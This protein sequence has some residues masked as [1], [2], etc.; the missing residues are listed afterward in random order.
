MVFEQR[1]SIDIWDGEVGS[2]DNNR[3]KGHRYHRTKRYCA[4]SR[5]E[6]KVVGTTAIAAIPV[7]RAL[8]HAGA[9]ALW[10]GER[11]RVRQRRTL[12]SE[13]QKQYPDDEPPIH[14]N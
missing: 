6:P 11:H 8:N 13:G 2:R 5:A 1:R 14:V 4:R 3:R 9:S 10:I 12:P 7:V